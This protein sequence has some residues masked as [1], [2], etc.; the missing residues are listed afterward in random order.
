MSF[1]IP[2]LSR[3]PTFHAHGPRRDRTTRLHYATANK[4]GPQI[5]LYNDFS[6]YD[7]QQK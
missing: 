3:R 6:H 5:R 1:R 4:Y 2:T 7:S